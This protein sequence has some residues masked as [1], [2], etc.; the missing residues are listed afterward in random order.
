MTT[1]VADE[2]AAG[3]GRIR[4]EDERVEFMRWVFCVAAGV[5]T[6]V[7][8]EKVASVAGVDGGGGVVTG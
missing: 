1:G 7:M 5:G 2:G 3:V 4:E 6:V 8:E